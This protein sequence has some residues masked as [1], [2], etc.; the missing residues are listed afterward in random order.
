[1]IDALQEEKS[2]HFQIARRST[3]RAG[4]EEKIGRASV[5]D[6]DVDCR[7]KKSCSLISLDGE[8]ASS[9]G[10]FANRVGTLQCVQGACR[11]TS[12]CKQLRV[13]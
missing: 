8:M 2:L 10:P 12:F 5:I 9:S 11:I 13:A 7:R 1:M 4:D 3:S 6:V